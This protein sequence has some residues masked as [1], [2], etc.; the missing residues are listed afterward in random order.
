[1][2]TDSAVLIEFIGLPGVGK[3][4][5]SQR[6]AQQFAANG[7][8]VRQPSHVLAHGL[9]RTQ[10]RFW[11]AAHV[12]RE[13]LLHPV[14]SLR[15]MRFIAATRQRDP[16]AR[17]NLAFNW[18]LVVALTRR[19][20]RGHGLHVF[21]QGVLQAIWSVA[22]EGD[23]D[24]A[25]ALL[26]HVGDSIALPDVVVL[27]EADLATVKDRLERRPE[28]DSRLEREKERAAE[29]LRRGNELMHRI[30]GALGRTRVAHIISLH[31]EAGADPERLAGEVVVALSEQWNGHASGRRAAAEA[32]RNRLV[33]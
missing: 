25:M 16:H 6:V 22:L 26:A 11:K 18:L 14:A 17:W 21:D 30:A 29:L 7:A 23:V 12:L 2:T 32:A 13:V 5:L 33:I 3:S 15:T 27:V 1:V 9:G 4:E 19:A 28:H 10:R 31:N 8:S 20:R 24:A